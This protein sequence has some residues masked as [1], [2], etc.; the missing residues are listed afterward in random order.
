MTAMWSL[1]AVPL[2]RKST[3]LGGSSSACYRPEADEY[4][5]I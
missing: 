1:A 3:P 5:E 4:A 2:K